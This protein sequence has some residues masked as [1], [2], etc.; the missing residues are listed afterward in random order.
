[1][2]SYLRDHHQLIRTALKNFNEDFFREN[3]IFFGGGTRIALELDE[4][5]ESIDIDFLCPDKQSYR[6]V[7]NEVTEYSLGNI[8]KKDFSYPREIRADRDAVRCFIEIDGTRIK[9]EF[10]SF[11]DYQ[12]TADPNAPFPVPALSKPSCYLTKLLANADRYADSPYK[13][14]FDILAMFL[15]WGEIPKDAWE[16]ADAHYGKSV[17]INGLIKSCRQIEENKLKYQTIAI[18]E[19]DI[20]PKFADSLLNITFPKFVDYINHLE[21]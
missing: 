3:R 1:M 7:R 4:Y 2:S 9:L 17:V 14:I 20:C 15:S 21:V 11:A 8:V 13:D 19:L 18:E 12:L 16:K 6:A 10:V 5:R